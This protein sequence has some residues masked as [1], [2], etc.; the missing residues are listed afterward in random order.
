VQVWQHFLETN[1][2]TMWPLYA[3]PGRTPEE[4]ACSLYFTKGDVSA[5]SRDRQTAGAG[6]S[7]ATSGIGLV[8]KGKEE[9]N[10]PLSTSQPAKTSS[11]SAATRSGRPSRSSKNSDKASSEGGVVST[12]G[13]EPTTAAL[14]V[15]KGGGTSG[16]GGKGKGGKGPQ[17]KKS[18]V[19]SS[20]DEKGVSS[21]SLSLSG[22]S[23]E[24]GG[25]EDK[26]RRL[27]RKA[28]SGGSPSDDAMLTGGS[29]SPPISGSG[30]DQF[31]RADS[32]SGE[33]SSNGQ[34]PTHEESL[35]G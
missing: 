16:G 22:G 14:F 28:N 17:M 20:V 18:D 25:D 11:S 32:G 5:S 34:S 23:R 31:N 19:S 2:E 27:Q 24:G 33:R 29:N 21:E 6:K 9:G 7:D 15:S 26:E 3:A 8:A 12:S 13:S 10:L 4:W 30:S 35:L 1:K